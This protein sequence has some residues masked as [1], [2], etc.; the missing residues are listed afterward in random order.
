MSTVVNVSVSDFS[1]LSGLPQINTEGIGIQPMMANITIGF[2]FLGGS[3]LSGPI[4]RLQNAVSYNFFANTSVYDRHA[5]Y[6][7][8]W[9]SQSNDNVNEWEAG[10]NEDLKVNNDTS[11]QK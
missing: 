10:I 7:D 3:D 11:K 1:L 8:G 5:D 2:K 4:S 6:R 9:I